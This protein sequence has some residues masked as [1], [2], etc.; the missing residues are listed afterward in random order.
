M[1]HA[2]AALGLLLAACGTSPTD[3]AAPRDV[4]AL[5]DAR[6]T[7]DAAPR[8][9][10]ALEDAAADA[11]PPDAAVDYPPVECSPGT[12]AGKAAACS[13]ADA[14]GHAITAGHGRADGT[15]HAVV[16]PTETHCPASCN[17]T[18]MTV[19]VTLGGA[20][21]RFVVTLVDDGGDRRMRFLAR[22]APLAGP[23]WSD[24]WHAGV[25]LDYVA[26]LGV[27]AADFQPL[28]RDRLAATVSDRLTPGAR[29]SVFATSDRGGDRAHL[30]HRY[31]RDGAGH[32]G[33]L[34]VDPDGAPTYL[35]FYYADEG[36][37]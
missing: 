11:A 4:G 5:D 19:E 6:P 33:A 37:F 17:A 31:T 28:D 24:G 20:P 1:R 9:L 14:L 23:P 18:H 27:H 13:A 35:L 25:A 36:G 7:D 21:H 16:V 10:G 30:V 3:G 15:I 26:D 32:D 34:V 2:S 8:D 29:V 12:P 22:A